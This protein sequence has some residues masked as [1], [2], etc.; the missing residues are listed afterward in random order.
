MITRGGGRDR[1]NVGQSL[2]AI[3]CGFP[4]PG[5]L[6]KRRGRWKGGL[7]RHKRGREKIVVTPILYECDATRVGSP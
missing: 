7:K 6:P 1:K 5:T 4:L 2:W 3:K